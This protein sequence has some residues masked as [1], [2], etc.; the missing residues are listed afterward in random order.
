MTEI[1]RIQSATDSA[2]MRH[3]GSD[4]RRGSASCR[5]FILRSGDLNAICFAFW[6]TN[7]A[8]DVCA[9]IP[10]RGRLIRNYCI[11][12]WVVAVCIVG[13]TCWADRDRD[14]GDATRV[15]VPW[16]VRVERD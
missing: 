10:S 13:S 5:D 15:V 6:P 4:E 12:E 8:V 7:G 3:C 16:N 1:N 9:S 14:Q 11:N 2:I